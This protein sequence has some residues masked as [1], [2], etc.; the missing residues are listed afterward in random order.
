MK[1]AFHRLETAKEKLN[2][3]ED[4]S[5]ETSQT[6]KQREKSTGKKWSRVSKNCGPITKGLTQ[7]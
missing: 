4:M 2:W 3:L 6:E 1:N 5:I 7:V